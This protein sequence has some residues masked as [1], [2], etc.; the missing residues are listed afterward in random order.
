MKTRKRRVY[1]Q[2]QER[3]ILFASVVIV[4]TTVIILTTHAIS[5]SW[6]VGATAGAIAGI[7]SAA[8]YPVIFRDRR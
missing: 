1:A 5:G 3:V 8:T 6:A 4:S 7:V 2:G